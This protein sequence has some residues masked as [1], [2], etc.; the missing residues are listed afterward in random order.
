M[1]N[2]TYHRVQDEI[3]AR[4]SAG[5]FRAVERLRGLTPVAQTWIQVQRKSSYTARERKARILELPDPSS[6][7]VES[8]LN[9]F[10]DFPWWRTEPYQYGRSFRDGRPQAL[11]SDDCDKA[12][13]I[14]EDLVEKKWTTTMAVEQVAARFLV[15]PRTMWKIWQKK[16]KPTGRRK[17][18]EVE[19]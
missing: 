13:E 2:Q 9:F 18:A 4:S 8:I 16:Y 5:L 19:K 17:Q 10:S 6:E 3:D 11:T 14:I 1:D 7:E 15:S 12:R